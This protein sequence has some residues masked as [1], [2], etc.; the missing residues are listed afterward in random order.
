MNQP[1]GI[2]N[3]V[4]LTNAAEAVAAQGTF[5]SGWRATGGAAAQVIIFRRPSAGAEY[6]RANVPIN[7]LVVSP[8]GGFY[9][10][11]GLE[12]L[13][14]GAAADVNLNVFYSLA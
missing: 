9:A 7:G 4:T 14:A 11:G 2:F 12:V 5:I 3:T 13:T 10:S 6:F 8:P 1:R